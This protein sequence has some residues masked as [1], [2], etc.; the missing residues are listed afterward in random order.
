MLDRRL[1]NGFGV[2]SLV[3][4]LSFWFALL[5]SSVPG[6]RFLSWGLGTHLILWGAAFLLALVPVGKGSRRWIVAM[7]LPFLNL[8]F[9]IFIIGMGEWIC[10]RPGPP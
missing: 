7:L 9:L 5:P 3:L 4:S 8:A 6:V 10:S 1:A 2:A